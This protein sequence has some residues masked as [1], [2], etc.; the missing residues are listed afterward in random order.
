MSDQTLDQL[1]PVGGV[2]ATDQIPDLE[3]GGTVLE[4]ASAQQFA[5]FVEAVLRVAA[6]AEPLGGSET[7]LGIQSGGNVNIGL[8]N[9][10]AYIQ[11]VMRG[12]ADVGGIAGSETL[13]GTRTSGAPITIT[14]NDIAA[15]LRANLFGAAGALPVIT[16]SGGDDGPILAALTGPAI[17]AGGRFLIESNTTLGSHTLLL[18]PPSGFQITTGVTFTLSSSFFVAEGAPRG[19]IFLNALAGQGRV[20]LS[21]TGAAGFSGSG[22]A[23]Y[24]EWWGASVNNPAI[25]CSAAITACIAAC[26]ITQLQAGA[27][28]VG[29]PI[30]I[31]QDG[32]TLRGV[33]PTQLCCTSAAGGPGTGVVDP[34]ATQI[35]LTSSS[36]MGIVVGTLQ[37]AQPTGP[38][39]QNVTLEDFTVVRATA[40]VPLGV[41]GAAAI[42][43]PPTPGAFSLFSSPPPP[44]GVVLCW[45]DVCE[46]RNV[47]CIE[48]SVGFYRYGTVE[49]YME[50][51]SAL[52]YTAGQN[53]ANDFWN[54]FFQDNSGPLG[55]NSGN[56]SAYMNLCRAFSNFTIGGAPGYTYSAGLQIYDGWTDTYITQFETGLTGYG[57]DAA[58]RTTTGEDFQTEDLIISGCVLDS[59]RYA[60][61]RI[62]DGGPETAV[63]IQ[64]CYSGP[65]SATGPNS[66]GIEIYQVHGSVN[67]QG[68]Q[69][70]ASPGNSAT[71]LRIDTSSGVTA[72]GNIYTDQHDPIIINQ[73]FNVRCEDIVNVAQQAP[74]TAA[75]QITALDRGV[76]DCDIHSSNPSLTIPIGIDLIGAANFHVVVRA[77]NI[78]PNYITANQAVQSDGTNITANGVFSTTCLLTELV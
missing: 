34:N 54:G 40:A 76:I 27:Y 45:V 3:A 12:E 44:C 73:S 33:G 41:T 8:A 59:P 14:P 71:G 36:A 16:P 37:P 32:R 46:L 75:V 7:L 72:R 60:G 5:A 15:W 56:A 28:Y 61:I 29:S 68:C 65:T 10:V 1:A 17:L 13:F 70:I 21:G 42:D 38:F 49:S 62:Q 43:N 25:D 2:A 11:T 77:G 35:V 51:C 19:S 52:R 4:R 57:I 31:T 30:T 39:V 48:H 22:A 64:N 53:S 67:I 6:S 9:L 78:D 23:G 66:I 20:V 24:P 74:A 63:Q 58:G 50:H 26:P 47:M 18:L 55:A 69:I